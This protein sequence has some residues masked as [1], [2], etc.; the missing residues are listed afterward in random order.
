MF[1]R[2]KLWLSTY[3]LLLKLCFSEYCFD[4]GGRQTF[5]LH[6]RACSVY[7]HVHVVGE[8]QLIL[9]AANL[10]GPLFLNDPLNPND[11]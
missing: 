4:T 5:R 6:N 3:L 10:N 7:V 1:S 11:L 9:P 2:N 8:C